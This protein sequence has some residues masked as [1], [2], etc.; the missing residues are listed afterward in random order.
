MSAVPQVT[1]ANVNIMSM[2]VRLQPMYVSVFSEADDHIMYEMINESS[3]I[4]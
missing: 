1:A 4:A 2:M 3:A